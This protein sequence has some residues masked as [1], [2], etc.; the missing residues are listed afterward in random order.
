[1][2][3]H[4]LVGKSRGGTHALPSLHTPPDTAS[5]HCPVRISPLNGTSVVCPDPHQTSHVPPAPTSST[6]CHRVPCPRRSISV[7]AP[8]C[9]PSQPLSDTIPHPAW[10]LPCHRNG[11]RGVALTPVVPP[12]PNVTLVSSA[13]GNDA[14]RNYCSHTTLRSRTCRDQRETSRACKG[15][16]LPLGVLNAQPLHVATTKRRHGHY[17]AENALS[18]G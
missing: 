18:I 16:N 5:A 8:T 2:V 9:S 15:V 10:T 14:H 13:G 17:D 11:V 1:M 7:V 6:R 12:V 3:S 4:N